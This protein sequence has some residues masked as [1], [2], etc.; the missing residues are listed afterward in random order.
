MRRRTGRG[1]PGDLVCVLT[2]HGDEAPAGF[3]LAPGDRLR[4]ERLALRLTEALRPE[5]RGAGGWR[6]RARREWAA[7]PESGAEMEGG[8]T[9]NS[10]LFFNLI[11]PFLWYRLKN[12]LL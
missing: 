11:I 8:P 7:G 6:R 12:E 5:G 3:W 9:G 4:Q 2:R 1:E 10:N